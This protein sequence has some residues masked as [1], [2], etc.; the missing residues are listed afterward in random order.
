MS[1]VDWQPDDIKQRNRRLGVV[2]GG[3]VLSM[4]GLSYLSVPLYELFCQVTGWS[5][6]PGRYAQGDR[7]VEVP[8][9]VSRQFTVQFDSNT[10][11]GLGWSFAPVERDMDI[12]MGQQYL[13]FYR[14]SNTGNTPSKGTATFNVT[15]LKFGQ[16]FV[17]VDCF[18]FTEQ[19]LQPG[20][21]VDMPV[22]FYIDPAIMD[23]PLMDDVQKITLSYTFFPLKEDG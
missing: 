11:G 5:G 7:V 23:E 13:A 22:S 21:T 6:T 15:P 16:Y 3:I 12:V 20:E 17:K 4:I 9:N 1:S 2:F 18:C 14:A 19:I 10:A 8:D